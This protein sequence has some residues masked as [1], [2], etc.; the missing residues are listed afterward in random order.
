MGKFKGT[1]SRIV[2]ALL[3]LGLLIAFTAS[4]VKQSPAGE[5]KNL[6]DK[7]H[8]LY[9]NEKRPVREDFENA[10]QFATAV[11]GFNENLRNK[12]AADAELKDFFWEIVIPRFQEI[13]KNKRFNL[14]NLNFYSFDGQLLI[15]A[16]IPVPDK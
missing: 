11:E 5:K 7:V 2:V 3:T 4:C 6:A 8:A 13:E 16:L 1:V 14:N 15:Y 10:R 9:E 12:V